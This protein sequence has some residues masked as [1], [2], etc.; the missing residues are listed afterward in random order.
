[1]CDSAGVDVCMCVFELAHCIDVSVLHECECVFWR[2]V[3]NKTKEVLYSHI[4]V[5]TQTWCW[6]I[7]A[8][9]F[10]PITTYQHQL[11]SK[12]KRNRF[13][14]FLHIQTVFSVEC[15]FCCCW[16]FYCC[17]YPERYIFYGRC[18]YL[19]SQVKIGQTLCGTTRYRCDRLLSYLYDTHATTFL[20]KKETLLENMRAKINMKNAC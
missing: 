15:G 8:E 4:T 19:P 20:E 17:L 13:S 11:K 5:N 10:R 14:Y 16:C 9:W 1:M 3:G 18:V 2:A 12:H 6:S 7:Q